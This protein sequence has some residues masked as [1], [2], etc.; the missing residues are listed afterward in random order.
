MDPASEHDPSIQCNHCFL[1]ISGSE[2]LQWLLEWNTYTVPIKHTLKSIYGHIFQ[3]TVVAGMLKIADYNLVLSWFS[4]HI[5]MT[6]IH[7]RRLPHPPPSSQP[8]IKVR[9]FL[10]ETF[11]DTGH[12]SFPQ[13]MYS[14]T[15]YTL[16][17]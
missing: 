15:V 13:V 8:K 14:E 6:T 5:K 16:E 1:N 4:T 7:C 2:C 11:A 17:N 9:I 12:I 3:S 10:A